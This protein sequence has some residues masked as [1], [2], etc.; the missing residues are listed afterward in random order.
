MDDYSVT[1]LTE[2]KNEWCARLVNVMTPAV[3][4]GLRSIFDEAWQLCVQEDEEEQYLK[5][6]QT[7]LSRVPKWNPE[8]IETERKRICEVSSCGYLE[9]LITCVHIIQLKALTCIRVGQDQKKIDLQVPSVDNFVHKAYINVARKV[10]TNVYLFEKDIAP[11]QIQKHNR[12]LEV[13]IKECIM[14]SIR[15]SMPVEDILKSYLAE[16]TEEEVTTTEEIIEKPAPEPVEEVKAENKVEAKEKSSSDDAGSNNSSGSGSN[17]ER[18]T[19]PVITIDTFDDVAN[20]TQD[21]ASDNTPTA[22]KPPVSS[23]VVATDKVSSTALSVSVNGSGVETSVNAPKDVA[24]LE[25]IS[26]EAHAR[27]KAEEAEDDEDDDGPLS[28][29]EEVRLEIADIHDINKKIE[30]KPAPA[31]DIQTL[32]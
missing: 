2:S 15:D 5:T 4:N 27:R 32:V 23:P 31:L 9:D 28:I 7:F 24:R 29:G 25:Q 22:P 19:E 6:F 1:S 13:I 21:T 26:K 11:L 10:Y 14:N 20:E 3:I 30:V 8:I 16:T 12:E 17:N 18:P